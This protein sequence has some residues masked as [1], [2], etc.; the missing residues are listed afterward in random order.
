M[1]LKNAIKRADEIRPND[2]SDELKAAWIFETEG[3]IAEMTG[4][5]AP[6][7][8]FPADTELLMPAPYDNIY[9]LYAAAMIDHAQQDSELYYNDMTMY[10]AALTAAMGWYRRHNVPEY[11]GNWRV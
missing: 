8:T 5:K 7:N 9:Y 10:N 3:V 2:I 11:G 1:T 6:E 4:K